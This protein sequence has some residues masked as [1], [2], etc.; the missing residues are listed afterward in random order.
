MTNTLEGFTPVLLY[1]NGYTLWKET[2]DFEAD[3]SIQKVAKRRWTDVSRGT[4]GK[5]NGWP[6]E[7]HTLY[8]NMVRR[9]GAQ[10]DMSALR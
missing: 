2:C 4:G 9:V 5:M 6:A 10:K 7:A 3:N 1:A 8:K